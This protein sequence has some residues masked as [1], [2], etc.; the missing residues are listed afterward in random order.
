MERALERFSVE[1]LEEALDVDVFTDPELKRHTDKYRSKNAQAFRAAS[2][3]DEHVDELLAREVQKAMAAAALAK[4]HDLASVLCKEGKYANPSPQ[5][6]ENMQSTLPTNRPSESMFALYGYIAYATQNGSHF[7]ISGVSTAKKNG[8]LRW[9]TG[10]PAERRN[11][12][13]LWSRHAV[14]QIAKDDRLKVAKE[15]AASLQKKE[16]QRKKAKE[17]ARRRRIQGAVLRRRAVK[18]HCDSAS[19]LQAALLSIADDCAKV[20]GSPAKK[21]KRQQRRQH[22]FVMMQLRFWRLKGVPSQHIPTGTFKDPVTGKRAEYDAEDLAKKLE[23]LMDKLEGGEV[24]LKPIQDMGAALTFRE[25][26]PVGRLDELLRMEREARHKEQQEVECEA[27]QLLREKQ[28]K[29]QEANRRR[30]GR[31]ASRRRRAQQDS[32]SDESESWSESEE[33]EESAGESEEE[34]ETEEA[35]TTSEE[36]SESEEEEEKQEEE[37]QMEG[38]GEK[39]ELSDVAQLIFPTWE[40]ALPDGAVR[41][42]APRSLTKKPMLGKHFLL[43]GYHGWFCGR[44]K[45][46]HKRG[47]FTVT[48]PIPNKRPLEVYQEFILG[49]YGLDLP[50]T[51]SSSA[52]DKYPAGTWLLFK[53]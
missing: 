46:Y 1:G 14:T 15:L 38:G 6:Q 26:A 42:P 37:S 7:T 17:A 50:T 4:L 51:S 45:R 3:S 43:R 20:G 25:A 5:Q 33:S 28:S 10:L 13:V 16:D 8:T 52:K 34:S 35:S 39:E 40:D 11:Q 18:E 32:E 30:Q 53:K 29:G 49:N 31:K 12:L 19:K 48:Y 9:L 23:D 2:T 36:E 24:E 41:Q 22:K 47:R 21:R 44:I 27:I